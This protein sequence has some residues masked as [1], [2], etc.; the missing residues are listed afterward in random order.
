MLRAI[1]RGLIVSRPLSQSPYDFITDFGDLPEALQGRS[2]ECRR[3][4]SRVQVKSVSVP[5]RHQAGYRISAG[6]GGSSRRPYSAREIDFLA[7]LVIPEDAWY[8]IPVYAFAPSKTVRLNPRHPIRDRFARYRE[9]WDLL[10]KE[11]LA[12]RS[13]TGL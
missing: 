13:K 12:R 3:S 6:F 7:A 9:A 10:T 8:I 2:P 4:I 1:E 11:H 5:D